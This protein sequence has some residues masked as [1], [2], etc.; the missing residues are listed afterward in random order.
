VRKNRCEQVAL[1][2]MDKQLKEFQQK[3]HLSGLEADWEVVKVA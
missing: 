1:V 2:R 3:V